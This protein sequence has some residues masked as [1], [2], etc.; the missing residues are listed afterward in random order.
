[1]EADLN[2]LQSLQE[3]RAMYKEALNSV[4]Q[5]NRAKSLASRITD[6]EFGLV[7][8]E[9]KKAVLQEKGDQKRARKG[10]EETA[11]DLKRWSDELKKTGEGQIVSQI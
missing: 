5:D 3:A 2:S 6:R 7:T 11:T 8:K 10:V 1:M 9:Y 4:C